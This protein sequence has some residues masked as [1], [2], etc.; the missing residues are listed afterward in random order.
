LARKSAAIKA[1]AGAARKEINRDKSFIP[2]A[3]I[4]SFF[5][6]VRAG[7]CNRKTPME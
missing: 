4:I 1:I 6:I 2:M 5:K 3:L 7:S